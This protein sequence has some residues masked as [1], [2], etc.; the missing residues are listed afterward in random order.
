MLVITCLDD[1]VYLENLGNTVIL[2]RD[3]ASG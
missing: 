3:I 2:Y 1:P